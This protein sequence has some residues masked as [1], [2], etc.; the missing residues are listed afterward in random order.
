S[1]DLGHVVFFQREVGNAV[2]GQEGLYVLHEG[3]QGSGHAADVG[4]NAGDDQLVSAQ[5]AQL[6]TQIGALEG[7]VAPFGQHDV[8]LGRC[9]LGHDGL[10]GVK[11]G[12]G[13]AWTPEVVQQSTVFLGLLGGLGGVEHG[14]SQLVAHVAQ[15]G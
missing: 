4:V 2:N 1:S 13:Q 12:G 8:L 7:A 3:F 11:F 6:L 9:Q 10:L 14:N 5:I 15:G